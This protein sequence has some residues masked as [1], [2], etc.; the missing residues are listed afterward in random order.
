MPET[1]FTQ[2]AVRKEGEHLLTFVLPI[3]FLF[4][5]FT[6]LRSIQFIIL[7]L[8]LLVLGS[9]AYSEYLIR[10]IRIVRRD[11]DLRVFRY[12]WIAA[13]LWVE[14]SGRLPAFLLIAEDFSGG[15]AVFRY[16]KK[17][18]TL[19]S[20]SRQ[21]F[22]WEAY[23]SSRGIY[24]IGPASLRGADPLA[25]FPFT[26]VFTETCRLFVYPAPAYAA[27][28]APGGIPLGNLIT[29]D[30]FSEDLTRPRSL[31]DYTPGDESRRI[32]WKA[33]AKMSGFNDQLLVNEYE[34]SLSYPLVLFLNVDPAE[35]SLKKREL[36]L[37]RVI[38]A[39]AAICLMAA[40]QRQV[41]GL[42]IHTGVAA[43]EADSP[44]ESGL[45]DIISPA[46][47]TLIPILERLAAL[48]LH[49]N[50]QDV[51][52]TLFAMHGRV[53]TDT[54]SNAINAGGNGIDAG[55][56]GTNAGDSSIDAFNAGSVARLRSSTERILDKG[57]ALPF[58]TRLVY[59]G[60]NLESE[61][62][63]AIEMLRKRRLTLEFIIIDETN[64]G[65]GYDGDPR[66]KAP[67]YQMKEYGREIV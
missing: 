14:N 5:I 3:L 26:I 17:L 10:H 4:F 56:S 59:C 44:E 20:R 51:R 62:Y 42:I 15:I 2:A 24:T 6:P 35:Y 21:L 52:E 47:F 45:A 38:E 34:S 31:R 37:E 40:R 28:K 33:S 63:H 58:G 30:P 60:P 23:G 61:D 65:L 9:K 49:M 41:I 16:I 19:G 57:K 39:G 53:G 22:R 48:K 64:L 7:F 18:C 55:G 13:D 36:Y 67:K 43:D 27:L 32:N 66:N 8:I 25:L 1:N 54:G 46:A 12:E 11:A 29:P 50:R